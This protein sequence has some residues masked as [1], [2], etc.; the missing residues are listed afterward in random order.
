ML[1]MHVGALSPVDFATS[2]LS[3]GWRVL[4]A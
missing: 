2:G 3:L 4:N 1:A